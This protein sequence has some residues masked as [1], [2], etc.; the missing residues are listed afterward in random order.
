MSRRIGERDALLLKLRT[1]AAAAGLMASAAA[2]AAGSHTLQV[3]ATV[4]SKNTCR[5]TNAGPSVLNFGAIDPSSSSPVMVSVGPTFRCQGSDPIATYV[6]ESDDGLNE[7]GA[8]QPRMLH[9][10]LAG[11]YLPYALN[12]PQSGSVPRNT[13][14]ILTVTGTVVP[15]GF[16][17][18]RVGSYS[19]TVVLTIQP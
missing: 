10:T 12:L 6:V 4:V 5:F 13:I 18:A 2:L 1:T 7:S 19:D 17:D 9:T 11:N 15:A 8:G 16:A 3:A 14:Q